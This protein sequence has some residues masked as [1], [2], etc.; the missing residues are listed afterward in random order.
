MEE[1]FKKW[2]MRK[3]HSQK[4]GL[5]TVIWK[6]WNYFNKEYFFELMKSMHERIK[7]FIKAHGRANQLLF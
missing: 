6:S 3:L 4:N 1:I 5:L 2:S 7:A